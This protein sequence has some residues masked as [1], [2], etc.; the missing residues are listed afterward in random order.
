[1]DYRRVGR[2]GLQVSSIG[3]GTMTW[4][5]DTDADE[6]SEQLRIFIEAGGTLIDTSATYGGGSAEDLIG[7]LL[8]EDFNR[9]DVVLASKAGSFHGR[10]D[11]SRM[12]LLTTLDLS[13]QRLGTDHLDVWFVQSYDEFV[14]PGEIADTLEYAI[15]S[16]RTRYV[17]VSNYPAWALSELASR[18]GGAQYLIAAQMEYSL[19][20]RGVEREVIPALDHYGLG[21]MAWSPLG[22]GVL[23]GKYRHTIPADSRAASP[24]L[25]G[26][27]EPYLND[28]ASQIVEATAVAS[29]GLGLTPLDVA[30]GWVRHHPLLA[31]AIVGARTPAQLRTVLAHSDDELPD[32]ILAAL[33][34]VTALEHRYP[35]VNPQGRF[36]GVSLP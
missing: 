35:E 19:L 29:E 17:G 26:F 13:L 10:V 11:S 34:D 25:R 27:V 7:S 4:G 33:D 8:L 22:R 14:D 21:L 24:H 6:A 9:D 31:S 36:R 32:E 20:E 16:G 2:S 28:R 30:L 15:K 5:R 1:M 12:S 23:T 18:L 3:L